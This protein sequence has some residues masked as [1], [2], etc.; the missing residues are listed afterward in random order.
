[1]MP[2]RPDDDLARSLLADPRVITTVS[3]I[4][5]L[6]AIGGLAA[7]LERPPRVIIEVLTSMQRHGIRAGATWPRSVI[8]SGRSPGGVDD[9]PAAARPRAAISRPSDWPG[10][11]WRP[12]RARSGSPTCPRSRRP[13]WPSSSAGPASDPVPMRLRVGTRLWLGDA[14][15]LTTRGDGAGRAPRTPWRS[16]RL[17][18]AQVGRDGWLVIMAGGTAHGIGMEAPTLGLLVPAAA[19]RPGPGRSAGDRSGPQPVHDR[20]QEALVPGTPAHA[21]QPGAAAGSVTPP[22]IGDEVPVELR[23]TTALVDQVVEV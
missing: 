17:P 6:A 1:M 20:R 8:I 2:W 5:D 13:P 21:G 16:R 19:G 10:R 11:R 12:P 18:A 23:L 7:E 3:R 22:A 14:G 9:P 4:E 15:S